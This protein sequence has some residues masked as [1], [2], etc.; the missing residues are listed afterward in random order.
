MLNAVT[1]QV[2]LEREGELAGQEVKTDVLNMEVNA[3]KIEL[4][5][6]RQGLGSCE[7]VRREVSNGSRV[8]A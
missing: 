2:T 3:L 1:C 5:R 8:V 6:A 4:R 7:A